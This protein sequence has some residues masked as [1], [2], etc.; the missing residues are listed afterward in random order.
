M[1]EPT[2]NKAARA[3]PA[4]QRDLHIIKRNPRATRRGGQAP[5]VQ[6]YASICLV[7]NVALCGFRVAHTQ[8]NTLTYS[9]S[10]SLRNISSRYPIT[11]SAHE[12]CDMNSPE[13]AFTAA[14][15]SSA[16]L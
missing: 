6:V 7:I 1:V 4:L 14:A 5:A 10:F 16:N 8:R 2:I 13:Y 12:Y 15:S 11:N 9:S 3:S